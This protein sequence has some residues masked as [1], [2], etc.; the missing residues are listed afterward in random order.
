MFDILKMY[1]LKNKLYHLNIDI[2]DDL[3]LNYFD[4]KK[5]DKYLEILDAVVYATMKPIASDAASFDS[6]EILIRCDTILQKA[7]NVSSYTYTEQDLQKIL[8]LYYFQIISS[9]LENDDIEKYI[10]KLES[11]VQDNINLPDN[12]QYLNEELRMLL[13]SLYQATGELYI[14]YED[15]IQ[16]HLNIAKQMTELRSRVSESMKE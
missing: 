7:I 13:L 10:T 3:F 15:K 4:N 12:E 6:D 8:I 14:K 1:E 2:D 16:H 11:L 9:Q 5:L